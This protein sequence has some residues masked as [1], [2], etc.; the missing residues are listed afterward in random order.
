MDMFVPALVPGR[1]IAGHV[2]S[3][4]ICV[5]GRIQVVRD[6]GVAVAMIPRIES[7]PTLRTEQL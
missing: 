2:D 6:T 7:K 4:R 5:L 1:P 3:A